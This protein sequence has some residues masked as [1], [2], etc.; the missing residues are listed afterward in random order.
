M[1][2]F[3]ELPAHLKGIL[4]AA[5]LLTIGIAAGAFTVSYAALW[6]LAK[7][8]GV[9]DSAV[10]WIWPLLIDAF[11]IVAELAFVFMAMVHGN[12]LLPGVL[13]VVCGGLSVWFNLIHA[14]ADWGARLVAGVPPLVSI[15]AT[16]LIG[17]ICKALARA[18]GKP[19]T[20]APP[21]QPMAGVLGPAQGV[22]YR[23]DGF[24]GGV[25]AGYGPYPVAAGGELPETPKQVN[26][27]G[28]GTAS[29]ATKRKAVETY[30]ASFK[31][32]ELKA[33]TATQVAQDLE[34]FEGIKVSPRHA[35]TFLEEARRKATK[36]R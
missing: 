1:N 9:V 17:A 6:D 21:P 27:S 12:R 22:L 16:V 10:A 11:L 32:E 18:L 35:Q 26:G 15:A 25:P 4:V 31:P 36:K 3:T 2:S 7:G 13:M 34:A 24:P 23:T 5:L 14:P 29:A 30:I 28:N 33:I 8:S 20:F 19:L